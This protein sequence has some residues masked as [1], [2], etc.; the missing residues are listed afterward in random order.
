MARPAPRPRTWCRAHS[1]RPCA[2]V[3]APPSAPAA[4]PTCPADGPARWPRHWGS[5]AARRPAPQARAGR[6]RL[7]AKASFSSITSIWSM[8][9][10][11]RSSSLRVAATGPMPMTRGATPAEAMPRTRAIG[12]Q[13]LG[14]RRRR[15][16]R[17][18]R[19]RAVIDA[20]GIARRHGL[21]GPLM[22]RSLASASAVVPGRGC[23]SGRRSPDRPCAGE[24]SPARSRRR[25]RRP[26]RPGPA[27][28]AARGE[29]VLIG[30]GDAEI[31]GHVVRRLGHGVGAVGLLHRR[32][33]EAPADGRVVTAF[34]ATRRRPA[35]GITKGARVMLSTPPAICMVV[36]ARLDPARREAPR[37]PCRWRRAG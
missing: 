19:R 30:A 18:E 16:P 13:A 9:Q 29:G 14:L 32:I 10:P 37:R 21:V 4:R 24:R 35:L 34:A 3:D 6:Q 12:R 36:I 20:R 1:A 25:K 8:R 23:S 2:A 5:H 27:R 31:L 17:S 33:D 7:G 26:H 22:P 11:S 15:A 28:L